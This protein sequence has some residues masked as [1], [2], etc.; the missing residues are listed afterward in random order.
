MVETGG[1][2]FEVAGDAG[3]LEAGFAGFGDG[4]LRGADGGIA[5][6]LD[7]FKDGLGAP[8]EAVDLAGA[9]RTAQLLGVVLIEGGIDAAEDGLERDAGLAPGL[10]EGPVEG[11]E[12]KERAAALL[13]AG[14]DLGE[15]VEVVHAA[16]IGSGFRLLGLLYRLSGI[17]ICNG[18][19]PLIIA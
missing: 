2:C 9:A 19:A 7:G 8:G 4:G 6:L 11:R 5:C 1:V 15:V 3:G 10:D 12:H 18:E 13:E 14:L 17:F 16:R